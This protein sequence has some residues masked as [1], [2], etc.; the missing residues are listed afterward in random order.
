MILSAQTVPEGTRLEGVV[1]MGIR[2]INAK[3]PGLLPNEMFVDM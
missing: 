2:I 1:G 3:V